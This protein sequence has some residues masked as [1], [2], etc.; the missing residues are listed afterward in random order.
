VAIPGGGGVEIMKYEASR[1]NATATGGGTLQKHA[2][3]RSGVQPWTNITYPQAV[4]ACTSIGARLC[5][6]TEWQ[7]MCEQVPAPQYPVAGPATTGDFVFLE[8]ED[9]FAKVTVGGRSWLEDPVPYRDSSGRSY[10]YTLNNGTTFTAAQAPA[11]SPRLDFRVNLAG[12]TTYFVWAR[13]AGDGTGSDS[14]WVG[15]NLTTPG[16]A[17]A[18]QVVN[19]NQ[20][21]WEW[22]P[23]AA[24]TTPATT[25]TY[26]VSVYMREDGASVDAIALTRQG[27]TPPPIDNNVWAYATN[28]KLPQPQAC[29]GD[30]YDTTP[31]G[32]DDDGILATGSL[33]SCFADGPGTAD[34]FDMSGNVKE[35]TNAR[36]PGQNPIRGGASNNEVSGLTCGLDFTLANDT[37]FFPNVGFR[38]CR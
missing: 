34:A 23:S 7:Q 25:G 21:V 27:T 33:P 26:T 17:N 30:P 29:N 9:A 24:I 3:S 13:L 2:C 18:T 31:G 32:L 8:A 12:N 22:R 10:M 15:I 6:E 20:L 5:T 35:W 37:F 36:S 16:T 11:N 38:C 14:V 19:I 28:P 1:P 4:A